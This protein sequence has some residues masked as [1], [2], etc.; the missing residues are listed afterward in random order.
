M[1]ATEKSNQKEN[2]RNTIINHVVGTT[3]EG[4]IPGTA[5]HLSDIPG[6][7]AYKRQ[8][9]TWLVLLS[10][11]ITKEWGVSSEDLC[12]SF[13]VVWGFGPSKSSINRWGHE[14]E[15]YGKPIEKHACGPLRPGS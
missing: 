7:Y 13:Q 8:Y 14:W 11:M 2:L 4:Y 5:R 15:E 6:I 1:Q 10:V 12:K 3:L 9:P